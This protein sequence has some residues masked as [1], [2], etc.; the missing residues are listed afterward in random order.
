L[1]NLLLAYSLQPLGI[2]VM[3]GAL[4]GSGILTA[5]IFSINRN[6]PNQKE[7]QKLGVSKYAIQGKRSFNSP[8]L[9]N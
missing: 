6:K 9:N 4:M 3:I 5:W 1:A 8:E 7:N 2:N